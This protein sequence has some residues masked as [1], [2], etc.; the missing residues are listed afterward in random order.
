MNTRGTFFLVGLLAATASFATGKSETPQTPPSA[1][2]VSGAASVA[3]AAAAADAQASALNLS[4]NHNANANH[5]A[6][7]AQGGT[8]SAGASAS[9]GGNTLTVNETQVRN[10]P[11]LGQG[12]F[13]I[14]GCGVAGNVGGSNTNGSGFFGFGFTP[15]QCYDF[16]LAQSYQA[17]GAYAAACE[18]LNNS[19]AGRRAAKRGVTLPVCTPPTPPA[20]V[21]TPTPAPPA[22]IDM[23][24]YVTREELRER[25]DRI[26][27]TL[28]SK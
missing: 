27:R 16:M 22:L 23:S 20:A 10:A 4:V 9:N 18:V 11:A 24:P 3:G 15:E 7:L 17:L 19:R 28:R 14:Q 1:T 2:S 8:S 13:A 21:V 12:S 26:V 25:D 5:N 6:A